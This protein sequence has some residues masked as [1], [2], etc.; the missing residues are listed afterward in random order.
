MMGQKGDLTLTTATQ[1]IRP[2]FRKNRLLQVLLAWYVVLW[3]LLAVRP[4]YRQ[5]WFLEN[6]LVIPFFILLVTTYRFFPF[7]NMSYLLITLFMSL[8]AVGAHYTY[9]EVPFG[10]WLKGVFSFSR[11]HFDRIVHFAFGLLMAYP[12]R[13]LFFRIAHSRGFWAYYLPIAMVLAFSGMFEMIEMI[14]ALIVSPELGDAYLGTQG[15][16]WDAQKDMLAATVGAVIA[17]AMTSV[18]R[19]IFKRKRKDL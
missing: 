11:N 3:V 17:M 2:N 19:N 6:L 1:H 9:A 10:F 12:A 15:D 7:S 5:D 4:L 18:L 13:E 8:H 16:S 14:A